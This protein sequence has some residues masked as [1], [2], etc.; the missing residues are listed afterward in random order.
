MKLARLLFLLCIVL[1]VNSWA[2]YT[3]KYEDWKLVFEEEFKGQNSDLS[4][5]WYYYYKF[6]QM[7]APS[8]IYFNTYTDTS[9]LIVK[10]GKAYLFTKKLD[11]P[12][13]TPD[14]GI[15]NYSHA[16]LRSKQDDF[17]QYND[18]FPQSGGYLYGMF[19]I[20]CKL[21]KVKGQFPAFWL[22]GNNAWPPE[23]DVFEFHKAGKKQRLTASVH[24]L[25]DAYFA[26]PD[27]MRV[28][29]Q[30]PKNMASSTDYTRRYNLTRKMHTY[31][32]I[33]TPECIIWCFD[34]KV[35]K[36]DTIAKHIP[37]HISA[38]Y[39][40]EMCKWN[41]MD[42]VVNSGLNYPKQGD[43]SIDNDPFIIEYVRVYKPATLNDYNGTDLAG[44][45]YNQLVPAYRKATTAKSKKG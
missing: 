45:F 12:V 28:R 32:V 29:S 17:P 37:G 11:Y 39:L 15:Y 1:P 40:S 42:I 23:I 31:S 18:R 43:N 7:Q 20:R 5:N 35:V 26:L 36:T 13:I 21:P 2:Q 10:E 6:G 19:E 38:K 24:W 41:K 14:S 16:L 8:T 22:C 27:S 44:Y 25:N 33:W 9:N 34:K 30:L 3:I 4:K